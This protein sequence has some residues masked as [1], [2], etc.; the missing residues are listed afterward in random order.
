MMEGL[1]DTFSP[2]EWTDSWSIAFGATY[3]WGSWCPLDSAGAK[4]E[5]NRSKAKQTEHQM[6]DFIKAVKLEVQRGYLK[7]KSASNSIKSQ[8][9]NINTAEETLKVSIK[10]FRNGIVDNTKLLE[11]NVG[12]TTAR[13]LYIQ[14]L[15]QYQEAKAEL[16]KAIGMEYFKIE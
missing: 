15:Y 3:R 6:D 2:P 9:G 8:E 11:A 16:N 14:S 1:N 4:T 10:Q 12:L 7:L 13:T 5:Q